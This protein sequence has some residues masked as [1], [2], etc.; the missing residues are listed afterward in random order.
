MARVASVR[1]TNF[2]LE[3]IRELTLRYTTPDIHCRHRRH[4]CDGG[5]KE[6]GGKWCRVISG[7]HVPKFIRIYCFF[8]GVIQILKVSVSGRAQWHKVISSCVHIGTYSPASVQEGHLVTASSIH[9]QE[10]WGRLKRRRSFQFS[11]ESNCSL[12]KKTVRCFP[13]STTETFASDRSVNRVTLVQ[14]IS[15]Y[16]DLVNRVAIIDNVKT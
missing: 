7:Y 6:G 5:I 16:P 14:N 4:E 9:T 15:R 3:W 1:P 11:R 10:I 13:Y 8:S 12:S 2:T